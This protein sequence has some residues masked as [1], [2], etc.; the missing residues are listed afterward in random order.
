[1]VQAGLASDKAGARN[2]SLWCAS[3]W[4]TRYERSGSGLSGHRLP[5]KRGGKDST[6]ATPTRA[7]KT[8]VVICS[9]GKHRAETAGQNAQ[10][11]D[12]GGDGR[13]SMH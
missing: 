11:P 4:Q 5:S 1:M 7:G 2:T 13:D 6:P 3:I 10:P 12:A 8:R 9:H